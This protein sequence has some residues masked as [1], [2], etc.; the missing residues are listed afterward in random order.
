MTTALPAGLS[1]NPAT[2]VISGSPAAVLSPTTFTIRATFGQEVVSAT[3]IVGKYVRTNAG[4]I[5]R[6]QVSAGLVTAGDTPA[7][8][9]VVRAAGGKVSVCV[10]GYRDLRIKV[11]LSAPAVSGYTAYTASRSYVVGAVR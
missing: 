5:A 6:V 7:N 3:V 11:V 2:G 8:Y 1:I 9:R 10:S 4:Q